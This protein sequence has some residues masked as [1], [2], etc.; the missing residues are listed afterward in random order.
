MP[1]LEE[2]FLRP[3]SSASSWVVS[4]ESCSC[5]DAISSSLRCCSSY[6]YIAACIIN[7]YGCGHKCFYLFSS[8]FNLY[9]SIFFLERERGREKERE[10]GR[11]GGGREGGKGVGDGAP[12]TCSVTYM[13]MYLGKLELFSML[14]TATLALEPSR[15]LICRAR[16]IHSPTPSLPLHPSLSP[17]KELRTLSRSVAA[18]SP[19]ETVAELCCRLDRN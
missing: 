1:S 12:D 5:R 6:I 7:C 17:V 4:S 13:Y 9:W 10:G 15:Q 19:A 2:N 3:S 16:D 11:E 14:E 18:P 8:F